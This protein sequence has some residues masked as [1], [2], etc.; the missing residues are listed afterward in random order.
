MYYVPYMYPHPYYVNVPM[1]VYGRQPV[2]RSYADEIEYAKRYRYWHSLNEESSIEL[3]DYG[4]EPFVVNIDEATKQNR[5][6]RTALWT[7]SNLQ[8]TVMSINAGED[9][10]LEVHPT[11]DQ[12]LRVEEGQGIVQMGDT[13][14]NLYFQERVYDDYAIMVP[15]GKWHNLTNTGDEPLKLYTIYA[16]PEH[17]FG[18]VHETKA[19][20]MTP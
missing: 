18:T 15:A 14:D 20:A 1:C 10:G 8:V 7:G 3:K 17:P 12:F 4:K 11:V 6:F 9:I 19:D 5:T 13:K 16:P 2:Y